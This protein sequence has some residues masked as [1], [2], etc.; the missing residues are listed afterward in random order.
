MTLDD[1]AFWEGQR[2]CRVSYGINAKNGG[3]QCLPSPWSHAFI[4]RRK[5]ISDGALKHVWEKITCSEHDFAV[6]EAAHDS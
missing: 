3:L 5:Y 2:P 6:E 4:M 1:K